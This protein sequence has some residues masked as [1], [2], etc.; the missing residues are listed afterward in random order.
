MTDWLTLQS[1]KD[2]TFTGSGSQQHLVQKGEHIPA[3]IG[4]M[5][6]RLRVVA[7]EEVIQGDDNQMLYTM[8]VL[9]GR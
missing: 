5:H 6:L 2:L 1:T 7:I 8:E 4:D 9:S 3:T